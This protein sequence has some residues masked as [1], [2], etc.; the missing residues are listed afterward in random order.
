MLA[1]VFALLEYWDGRCA[2]T[3]IS[4]PALLRASHI[5]S[6]ATCA[7]D[8][9]RLDV[10][11]GLLLSALWDAAFDTGLVSFDEMG[12]ALIRP[13][14]SAEARQVLGSDARLRRPPTPEQ[15][16]YLRE[17]HCNFGH[18]EWWPV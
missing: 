13:D 6:W 15:R 3:G 18:V 5:V 11:N 16:E 14:V 8:A 2:V 17:H 9:Q 12:A 1:E 10:N 7:S 4:D